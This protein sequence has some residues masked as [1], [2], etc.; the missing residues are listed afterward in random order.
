MSYYQSKLRTEY[1]SIRIHLIL[2]KVPLNWAMFKFANHFSGLNW[3]GEVKLGCFEIKN[4]GIWYSTLKTS[5]F[6]FLLFFLIQKS[7]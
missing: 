6:A 2:E 3:T 5:Q 7:N 4:P 1:T